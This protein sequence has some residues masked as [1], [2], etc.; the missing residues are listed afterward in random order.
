MNNYVPK[1]PSNYDGNQILFNSN[2]LIFNAKND[3]IF[4]TANK[5]ISF[6]SNGTINF[7]SKD[8]TIVNSPKIY[9]GLNS[10]NEEEPILLGQK[11]Y[12]LLNK[13]ISILDSLSSDL[14]SV[15]STPTGT[16]IVQLTTA[17]SKMKG[18]IS[19]LKTMLSKIK[20]KQNYTE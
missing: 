15:I 20:S 10:I 19:T 17:G 11:T 5:A 12:D 2:R 7:D 16:T 1:K 14:T 6:A 8:Y 18:K 13:I 9:L 3:S 4:L